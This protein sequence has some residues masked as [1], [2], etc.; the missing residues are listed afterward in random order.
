MAWCLV[1]SNLHFLF[2]NTDIGSPKHHNFSVL[3]R[4]MSRHPSF[5]STPQAVPVSTLWI[6]CEVAHAETAIMY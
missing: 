4:T 2:L 1:K 5:V 6:N 3:G